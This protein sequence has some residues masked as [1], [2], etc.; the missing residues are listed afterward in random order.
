MKE[1]G[2]ENLTLTRNIERQRERAYNRLNELMQMDDK[3]GRRD[4]KNTMISKSYPQNIK[5]CGE[6]LS[7]AS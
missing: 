7:P 4:S 3:T 2:L 6:P 5:S 1:E